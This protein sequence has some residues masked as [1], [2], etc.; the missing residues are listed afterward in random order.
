[1]SIPPSS[2]SSSTNHQDQIVEEIVEIVVEEEV[3]EVNPPYTAVPLSLDSPEVVVV[4]NQGQAPT[5]FE[6]MVN[7][8]LTDCQAVQNEKV[9]LNV[10]VSNFITSK[11][12]SR[13]DP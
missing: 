5:P 3:E 10:G 6:D 2:S 1:M 11:V 9:V 4:E 8:A 13:S 7:T 12:S